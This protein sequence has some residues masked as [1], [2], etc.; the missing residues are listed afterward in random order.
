MTSKY[1]FRQ[2]LGAARQQAITWA[3]VD[4]VPSHL[5]A[6]L[7]HN[8]E[9]AFCR[10]H[11]QMHCLE[12]V[13]SKVL[14]FDSN[15]NLKF[16][17]QMDNNEYIPNTT[18]YKNILMENYFKIQLNLT[19]LMMSLDLNRHPWNYYVNTQKSAEIILLH[20]DLLIAQTAATLTASH[21]HQHPL[22]KYVA[23]Q[24]NSIKCSSPFVSIYAFRLP[25]TQTCILYHV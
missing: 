21:W 3:Y 22:D 2:W 17:V 9:L 10:Q 7:G 11:F 15:F 25:D 13:E 20:Y 18:T 24:Y 1:W 14:Y 16:R 6:S 23:N 19:Y 8:I 5:M 4:S 12:Y